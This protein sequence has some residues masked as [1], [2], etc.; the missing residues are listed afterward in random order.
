MR[1]PSN[2]FVKGRYKI[3]QYLKHH[4]YILNNTDYGQNPKHN[5]NTLYEK[6]VPK[7]FLQLICPFTDKDLH[8]CVAKRTSKQYSYSLHPNTFMITS[9]NI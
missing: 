2:I 6:K 8:F 4:Y 1:T 7:I 3:I 9:T 5:R